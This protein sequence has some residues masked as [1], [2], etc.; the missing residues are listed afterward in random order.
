MR[1]SIALGAAV[2]LAL[3][4]IYNLNLLGD[5]GEMARTASQV[6]LGRYSA[7]EIAGPRVHEDYQPSPLEPRAGNYVD[8]AASF[9]PAADSPAKLARAQLPVRE[10]ADGALVGS[11]GVALR[12]APPSRAVARSPRIA[13]L[14]SGR[15]AHRSGC[16]DLR[17]GGSK[18]G[19]TPRMIQLTPFAKSVPS[20]ET[21]P[22][23][24]VPELAELTPTGRHLLLLSPD[25]G[26][27]AILLGRFA[28]PPS[29]QLPSVGG[30]A[31][32]LRIPPDGFDRPWKMTVASSVP[33]TVCGLRGR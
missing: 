27:T 14:L 15:A 10:A 5:G 29:A 11:L 30:R 26:R 6:P 13:R 25:L 16:I 22:S 20:G 2:L 4:V 19:T 3:G 8:A 21:R 17:P 7:Y 24:T 18:P 23:P 1:A 32:S 31:A 33:V 9:G 12:P 28:E